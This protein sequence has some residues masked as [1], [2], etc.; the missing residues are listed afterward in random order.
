MQIKYLQLK[1]DI[2]PDQYPKVNLSLYSF[3]F[4]N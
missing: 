2:C 1:Q 3:L 4:L